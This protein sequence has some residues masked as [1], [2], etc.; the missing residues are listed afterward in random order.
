M[1]GFYLTGSIN[2]A[3]VD[4]AFKLVGS[5]LQPGVTRVPDGEPGDRANWVL[6]QADVFLKNPTLDVVDGKVRVRPGTTV[7][8]RLLVGVVAGDPGAHPPA[9]HLPGQHGEHRR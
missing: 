6:T 3:S 2:V 7:A 9:G 4:D 8:D 1:A 5:R